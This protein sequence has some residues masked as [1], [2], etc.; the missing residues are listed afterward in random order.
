M[1]SLVRLAAA[2]LLALSLGACLENL[3]DAELSD[4][5]IK[6]RIEEQLKA[7]RGLDMRYITLDVNHRV[8]TLSGIAA[9]WQEKQAISNIVRRTQGVE[10]AVINLV[11]QE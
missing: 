7:T 8:V 2:P 10:Q 1:K 11:V 9:S 4:P 5:G 3:S 6:A